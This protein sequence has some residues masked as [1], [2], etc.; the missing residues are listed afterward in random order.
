M[1][2]VTYTLPWLRQLPEAFKTVEKSHLIKYYN[3]VSL[4]LTAA[5]LIGNLFYAAVKYAMDR[6]P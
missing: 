6:I 3:A 5:V 2:T 4:A 1:A